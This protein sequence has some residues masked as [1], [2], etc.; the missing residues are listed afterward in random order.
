MSVRVNEYMGKSLK[1]H[2]NLDIWKRGIKFVEQIYIST[3]QFPKEEMYGLTSQLRRAA[4][5][6]PSNIAE[7]A[8]RASKKEYIQF[9]YIALASLSEL[10]TQL[11]IAKNLNYVKNDDLLEEIVILRKMPIKFIRYLKNKE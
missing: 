1:T 3:R 2:K 11:V 6:F 10:E 5:S 8:A 9:L 4:V 7:G